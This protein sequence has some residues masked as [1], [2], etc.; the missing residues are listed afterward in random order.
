MNGRSLFLSGMGAVYVL[1]FVSYLVQYRGIHGPNG[2]EPIDMFMERVS[3]H[4]K[5]PPGSDGAEQ[6]FQNFP[7]ILWAAVK[8]GIDFN[9]FMEMSLAVGTLC[10]M[11]I[12]SGVHN[13]LLFTICF[14]VYHTILMVG[15][16][17]MT[18]QWD[19]LILE[20]GFISIFYSGLW[21]FKAAP[22]K[23]SSPTFRWVVRVLAF[24]L[25]LMTGVVKLQ[26][27]C[28]TW[29][30]LT[31][32][33]YHFASQC[34]PTPASFYSAVYLP[35]VM[36]KYSLAFVLFSQIFGSL[37]MIAP[38]V[39]LRRIGVLLQI[40]CMVA[41]QVSGNYNWF[42]IHAAL[43]CLSSWERDTQAAKTS[44][45]TKVVMA[46]TVCV[47]AVWLSQKTDP[48]IAVGCVLL[49]VI[50]LLLDFKPPVAMVRFQ[51]FASLLVSL[52]LYT[53]SFGSLLNEPVNQLTTPIIN[54]GF[55]LLYRG[56]VNYLIASVVISGLLSCCRSLEKRPSLRSILSSVQH[57]ALTFLAVVFVVHSLSPMEEIY[58][59]AN[60]EVRFPGQ[61]VV[62]KVGGHFQ[63][64][65][66]FN[67]YGLFRRMTG[68]GK[69]GE[70]AVPVLVL[71][72]GN[73]REGWTEIP[74]RYGVGPVNRS[75]PWV[76]PHQP[77]LDWRMWFA[78]LGSVHS[79]TWVL[80]L[81]S[82]LLNREPDVENLVDF[83]FNTTV[84]PT[85]AIRG[86]L[87]HYDFSSS[88]SPDTDWWVRTQKG[89]WLQPITKSD[90]VLEQIGFSTAQRKARARQ[91]SAREPCP[92]HLN[93][94]CDI[95]EVMSQILVPFRKDDLALILQGVLLGCSVVI[96]MVRFRK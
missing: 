22:S 73:E 81:A 76:A 13:C 69:N 16:K 71:E 88:T 2:I 12:L 53:F 74:L 95:H 11:L 48:K 38:F 9:V 64:L 25:F 19:I 92:G 80:A 56:I 27:G 44:I 65:R 63:D 85:T 20:S 83:R 70:V 33:K 32:L 39:V 62:N 37:M 94:L 6:G 23:E 1:A 82:G 24:K 36:K 14:V 47:V 26:S 66:A 84:S 61:A 78:A 90:R 60:R 35:E 3:T 87:Y 18:F 50:N 79:D 29:S 34:I 55:K 15:Q 46:I 7:M 57:L 10:A 4:Y 75:P 5:I 67:G 43:I 91:R 8:F 52:L 30:E 45:L 54:D 68:V 51:L 17:M 28:P 40:V 77:R 96:G 42:N 49:S 58:S 89:L 41:I 31:A 21:I 86:V 93:W 72:Y 59:R